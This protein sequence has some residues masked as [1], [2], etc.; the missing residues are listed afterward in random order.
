MSQENK[1]SIP[2]KEKLAVMAKMQR[3]AIV[4]SLLSVCT[5]MP[6]VICDPETFDDQ[7]LLYLD[8]DK[9]KEMATELKEKNEPVQILKIDK[10]QLLVFFSNLYTM[11]VNSVIIDDGSQKTRFQLEEIVHRVDE[12]E[13]P[14]GQFRIENPQF[15]LTALYLMQK[16]VHASEEGE[17]EEI[18]ELRE[19][20]MAHFKKGRYIVAFEEK[21]GAPLLT[22][23]NGDQY[24]PI[25]TDLL[26]FQKFNR[27]KK[28]KT[29]VM[30]A[31]KVVEIIPKNVKGVAVNPFGVNLQ[32]QI[33]RKQKEEQ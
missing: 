8:M 7:I 28:F 2:G 19:E 32:L 18:N 26:E 16:M 22:A 6:Y 23:K 13:I 30:E 14:E 5:R 4:Y 17:Q 25:F 3:A 27:E 10:N 33:N 31:S 1:Q 9:A 12:Q 24:Q 21:K 29:A 20:A 11:G 15:H